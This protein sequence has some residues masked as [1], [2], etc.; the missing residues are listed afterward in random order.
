M[1]D[2]KWETSYSSS[3]QVSSI[4]ICSPLT[5]GE[6]PVELISLN[7]ICFVQTIYTGYVY[8]HT[9]RDPLCGGESTGTKT[10]SDVVCYTAVFSVETQRSSVTTLKTAMQQ[11]TQIGLLCQ[12]GDFGAIYDHDD[13]D[14]DGNDDGNNDDDDTNNII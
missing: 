1:C 5:L 10:V 4:K 13:D 2:R 11:T 9:Q 8:C 3:L 14:A 6:C 12:N 7:H